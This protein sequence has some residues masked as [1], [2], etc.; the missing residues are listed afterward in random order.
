MI[1]R[2]MVAG[3]GTGGH[4][5]PGLAVVE[6]L[7]GRLPTVHARFVGTARG[8]ESRVLPERGEALDLLEVRPLKGQGLSGRLSSLAKIPV[9]LREAAALIKSFDPDLVLAYG[10][11]QKPNS[12]F[13][14]GMFQK[15]HT[16]ETHRDKTGERG[17]FQKAT[18]FR[19][20]SLQDSQARFAGEIPHPT[21]GKKPG[22]LMVVLDLPDGD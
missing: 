20:D 11:D 8:I 6:E 9:A 10:F 14:D 3:G 1:Q 22:W 7:R 16:G 17:R 19:L 21:P 4:L 5:F 12:L 15:P 13:Q 2:I 18:R